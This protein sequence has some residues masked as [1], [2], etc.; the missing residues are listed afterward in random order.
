M[1]TNTSYRPTSTTA[2]GPDRDRSGRRARARPRLALSATPLP[3][4]VGATLALTALTVTSASGLVRVFDGRSWVVPVLL[5]AIGVHAICWAARRARLPQPAALALALVAVWAL[6][7][8]TVLATSTVYGFPG[9]RTASQLWAALVQAHTAFATAVSPV[10]SSITGFK[11]VSVLGIGLI[12]ILADWAA[13][14]WRSALYGAA[15]PFAYFVAGCS[16]G[17][18]RGRELVVTAEVVALLAFLLVHRVTVGRADQAWFGNHRA[19][20]AGWAITAGCLTAA[21]SLVTAVA[22]TPAV[23]TTE[24]TGVL[25]WRAGLG[26]ASGPRQVANPV[27]DLHTRLI[28]EST[29]PVFKVRSPVASY[30][31]LTSLNTFTGQD[32]VSTDTYHGFGSH[33]PGVQAVPAGTRLVQENFHIEELDSVWLPDAFTPISVTGVRGVSYD[34]NSNSLITSKATSNGLDFT[35]ESY[36]YLSTLHPGQLESAPPVTI[37]A[38]LRPYLQLPA[39]VPPDVY[40]LAKSITASQSTEYGKALA[41]QNFFLGPDFSYSLDPPDDGYGISSLTNFLF[42]TREGYC[43]QFAGSY[44]VLA[45]AIGL[46]TRLAVGFATGTDTDGTYQVTDA[47]AHTWP[48]VYFGP[49]FG[50]LPFE[51][52]QS[53][54]DPISKGYAPPSPG[55]GK[56]SSTTAPTTSPTTTPPKTSEHRAVVAPPTTTGNAQVVPSSRRHSTAAWSALLIVLLVG[57]AWFGLIAG[58]RRARWWVRRWRARGDAGALVRASWDELSEVLNWWG[59]CRSQSETDEEFA[60]RAGRGI[61]LRLPGQ[62]PWLRGEVV[63]L[64]RLAT[65]AAFAPQIGPQRPGEAAAAARAIH[66][67]LFRSANTRMR[68]RWV[69]TPRPGRRS[70]SGLAKAPQASA[71][72]RPLIPGPWDRTSRFVP[73]RA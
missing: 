26:G 48:E 47:D 27:V 18:G 9:R 39:T 30:W 17:Q 1:L 57:I 11:L 38:S 71:G 7:A 67:S 72:D 61:A 52:T 66:R 8:W 32:W 56:G 19:G 12:A 53:F 44:A 13:F 51:P 23:G 64:A 35:V 36:Q 5:T 14:R 29:T 3:G 65:E 4:H 42:H 62:S 33:L 70:G 73:G 63:R 10:S 59:T 60:H 24:G 41:L 15:P 16:F 34:P 20:T 46:P 55:G 21:A 25:G 43:Q 2:E 22:I 49:N 68:L 54:S 28:F 50:W 31:R 45:R 37:T 6:T 58:G 40:A 69:L